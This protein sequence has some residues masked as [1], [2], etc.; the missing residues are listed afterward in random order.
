MNKLNNL[1]KKFFIIF[2]ALLIGNIS[3][4]AS[5]DQLRNIQHKQKVTH[6]KINRLKILEKL[7]KNKLYKNQQRLEQAST[8]LENSK[9]Q[10]SNME[11]QLTQMERELNRSVSE[12]NNANAGMRKRMRQ[13]YKNQRRGMFELIFTAKDLNSLLDTF[14]RNIFGSRRW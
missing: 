11:S 1:L 9:T 10:Y 6:E 13:V 7:E 14:P 5:A 4:V 2:I 8:N 3:L 12:F